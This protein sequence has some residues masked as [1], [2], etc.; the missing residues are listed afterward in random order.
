MITQGLEELEAAT[1][2]QA[3]ARGRAARGKVQH[4][5]QAARVIQGHLSRRSL[6]GH[7]DG[8]TACA[9]GGTTLRVA[10]T[11]P[12]TPTPCNNSR[13][14][15]APSPQRRGAGRPAPDR[16]SQAVASVAS[17][18]VPSYARSKALGL[19]A[20]SLAPAQP[21]QK[22]PQMPF[23]RPSSAHQLGRFPGGMAGHMRLK[24][25]HDWAAREGAAKLHRQLHPR[26]ARGA[27]SEGVL[28]PRSAQPTVGQRA[29]AAR[30]GLV[31]L[32]GGF[33]SGGVGGVGGAESAG[34]R[35][36]QRPQSA[37][38]LLQRNVH[39][40]S[41]A[42]L[43]SSPSFASMSS[44]FFQALGEGSSVL[45]PEDAPPEAQSVGSAGRSSR[46]G[47]AEALLAQR[48]HAAALMVEDLRPPP[49]PPLSA[50]ELWQRRRP[51]DPSP[52]TGL[53]PP[54]SPWKELTAVGDAAETA[55]GAWPDDVQAAT[56]AAAAA[57]ARC[58]QAAFSPPT[59]A[60][61]AKA[62]AAISLG[63]LPHRSPVSP[64]HTPLLAAPVA[65]PVAVVVPVG[66]AAAAG[67][68]LRRV[69]HREDLGA[70]LQVG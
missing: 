37:Q 17:V 45:L 68:T 30:Q 12:G 67:A 57:A 64:A 1:M 41:L 10:I 3:A 16:H 50:L 48:D 56:A 40:S 7:D 11:S 39:T 5:H 20:L 53:T 70:A 59:S 52:S 44:S 24:G 26:A 29:L 66:S 54:R 19:S 8:D 65:V 25:S 14:G 60:M 18:Q 32:G 22:P 69:F 47:F 36:L 2:L 34:R 33:S 23:T 58:G 62:E 35:T 31:R 6:G 46:S 9:S 49:P 63:E 51:V 13:P 15:S 27:S 38:S 4:E 61:M 28:R 43:A 55:D 21:Y 42:S